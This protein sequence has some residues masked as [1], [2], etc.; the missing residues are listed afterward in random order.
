MSVYKVCKAQAQRG[1][2]SLRKLNL[3]LFQTRVLFL[4]VLQQEYILSF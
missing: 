2:S 4:P 1:S 3:M